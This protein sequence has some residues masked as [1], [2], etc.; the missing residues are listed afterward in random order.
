MFSVKSIF[1]G[2]IKR[3]TYVQVMCYFDVEHVY[4]IVSNELQNVCS[5]GLSIHNSFS[6]TEYE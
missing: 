3:N 6:L 5:G 2:F 1:Y 4:C